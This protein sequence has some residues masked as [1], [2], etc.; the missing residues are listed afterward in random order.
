LSNPSIAWE[1]SNPEN[2]RINHTRFLVEWFTEGDF[3]FVINFQ[4]SRSGDLVSAGAAGLRAEL[5]QIKEGV[6]GHALPLG[7]GR[8]KQLNRQGTIGG[9]GGNRK[10]KASSVEQRSE[11][12]CGVSLQ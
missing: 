4:G 12:L 2:R 8:A 5:L 7:A 3:L 6:C 9:G 10:H 11:G 1:A